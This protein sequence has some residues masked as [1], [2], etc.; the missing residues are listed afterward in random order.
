[1]YSLENFCRCSVVKLRVASL[2]GFS[3]PSIMMANNDYASLSSG[4]SS[5]VPSAA[6]CE[7]L[8]RP[9]Y[10]L[11][12]QHMQVCCCKLLAVIVFKSVGDIFA[13]L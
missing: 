11:P 3:A 12:W 4:Y 13:V 7:S 8:I 10:S 5:N 9:L 1:M 6:W 2:T